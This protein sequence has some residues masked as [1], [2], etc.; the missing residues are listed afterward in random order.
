MMENA[1]PKGIAATVADADLQ[2]TDELGGMR[3]S[4]PVRMLSKFA[5]LGD[6]PELRLVCGSVTAV[7]LATGERRL[8]SAGVRMLVA[9]E[10]ATRAKDLV[11]D[12]VD[13]TRP[14]SADGTGDAKPEPGKSSAKEHTSFPSGHS[15]GAVAVGQA[16]ARAYPEYG[17]PARAAAGAIAVGQIPKC[18]HYPTDV[19]AGAAV[20][21]AC[22]A[23]IAAVWPAAE[24]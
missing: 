19:L 1:T 6:Q 15:A 2:A 21:I 18:A 11:K 8:A 12:R 10:L 17:L 4:L 7:G 16:F 3:G 22:E 13:R 24:R 14:R 9:H 20:G 23:A 5:K